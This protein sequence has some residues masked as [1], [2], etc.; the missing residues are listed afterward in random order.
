LA[1]QHSLDKE[2]NMPFTITVRGRL[3]ASPD[4]I[5]QPHD[6]AAKAGG[7]D[8]ALKLGEIHHQVFLNPNDR[9]QVLMVDQWK[10]IEAFQQFTSS[11]E[12]KGFFGQAFEGQPEVIIWE[13]S[14]WMEW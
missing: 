8:Q 6:A 2:I 12:I 1:G 14:D 11:P 3:K 4:V 10:T 9:Q 7:K 13:K 5:R